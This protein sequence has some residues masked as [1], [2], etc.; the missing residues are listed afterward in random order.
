MKTC[1]VCGQA[2]PLADFRRRSGKRAGANARRGAC[3]ACRE[4]DA[5]ASA[6]AERVPAAGPTPPA[7]AA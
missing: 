5:G 1:I 2:K 7:V 4:R 6:V 3:R